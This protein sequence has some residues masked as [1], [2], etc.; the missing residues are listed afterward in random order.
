MATS[1]PHTNHSEMVTLNA[2]WAQHT[3]HNTQREKT[4][5]KGGIISPQTCAQWWDETGH[6][7]CVAATEKADVCVMCFLYVCAVR[8]V[9]CV[10]PVLIRGVCS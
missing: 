7:V 9:W 8:M 5:E 4:D 6:V 2:N 3:Q 10:L 1:R